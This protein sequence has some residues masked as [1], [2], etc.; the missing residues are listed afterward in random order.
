MRLFKNRTDAAHELARDLAFLKDE[1]PLVLGITNG[2]LQI[3]AIIA[4]SLDAPLDI[5]LIHKLR[6]PDGS[7]QIVG[8]VDE[9]GR[10]SMIQ[11]TSRWRHLTTQE[12][13]PAARL[14]FRDLQSRQARFRAILPETEVRGRTVL[15][16]DHG[17]ETGATMLAAI[18]SVRDR[19]ARKVVVAAPAGV[20]KATWHLQDNADTVVIPHVPSKFRGINYF[21]EVFEDIPDSLITS[22]LQRWAFSRPEQHAGVKTFILRIKNARSQELHCELDLPP[23][24][25]RGSGPYPAVIFAHD[26]QSDA[27][28][29]RSVPI[30][31]RL[32][33]RGIIGVRMDFTGHGRSDGN[34]EK[35][36]LEQM[37]EDLRAVYDFVQTLDEVD[38]NSIGLNGAGNGGLIALCNA[39][40]NNQVKALVLR[41]PVIGNRH[42]EARR[43]TAPTLII[44]AERDTVLA[45]SMEQL[46]HEFIVKHQLLRI[47]D[48][49][50][51]FHDPISREL[52]VS[53]SVDWL[54]QHLTAK[55][56][57]AN[58]CDA[59]SQHADSGDKSED[60]ASLHKSE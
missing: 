13:I 46:D 12:M 36:T 9:H 50:R 23:G 32:A 41:G 48:S 22:I 45:D 2:G 10:I 15:I 40:Y 54:V 19:G 8:A 20:N 28:S 34:S 11:S 42:K 58:S 60:A 27:K 21:Y 7:E 5:L 44:H 4:E 49:T 33:K 26:L 38:E 47:P 31:R 57:K 52:M 43:V 3:A 35:V 6:A 1:Q 29:Q 55:T 37:L 51:L 53:A 25:T 16:V 17:I 24:V 14:A 30:S 39:A 18:A 56:S 59:L